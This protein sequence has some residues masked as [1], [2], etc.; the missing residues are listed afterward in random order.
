MIAANSM[1]FGDWVGAIL[2]LVQIA[3]IVIGA[4]WAYYK[5]VKGRVWHRRAEPM[6]EATLMSNGWDPALRTRVTLRNTGAADVPLR[7]T[8]LTI[9]SAVAGESDGHGEANWKEIARAHAFRDHESVESQETI[10]DDLV[11]PLPSPP[12]RLLAYRVKCQVY[13]KRTKPG[14]TCWTTHTIIPKN[15]EAPA[16]QKEV[17]QMREEQRPAD[18][19]EVRRAEEE[20]APLER[21][22]ESSEEEVQQAERESEG[23]YQRKATEDEV[24]E[25]EKD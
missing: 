19:E 20:P 12:E 25:A 18:E 23:Q 6:V 15:G 21:Q 24:R 16:M 10:T 17:A 1:N 3:A 7:T 4:I 14:A 22:R 2:S 13:D 8:L 5:F 9:F 11:I